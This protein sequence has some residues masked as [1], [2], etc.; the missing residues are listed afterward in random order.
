MTTSEILE[1]LP[2][3]SA[4]VVGDICLDRWCTYDPSEDEPSRETGIPRVGVISTTVTPGAGGT[5]ANNLAAMGVGRVSVLGAIGDDGFGHELRCAL[6]ARRIIAEHLIALPNVQ[7]FT[8]TK[9]INVAT[10]EEDLPRIDFVCNSPLNKQAEQQLLDKLRSNI[11]SFD[12]ILVSDQA[13]TSRGGVV[14]PALRQLLAELAVQYPD[15]IFMADSRTR[16][17]EFRNVIVKPNRQEAE[18]A[19]QK[20]FGAIDYQSLLR[21]VQSP[22]LFVTHGE[23]GVALITPEGEQRVAACKIAK[24][25]DIC[26]A[27]DSF[28]AGAAMA[29]AVTGSPIE[30]AQFGNLVASITIMKKGT[31]TASPEELSVRSAST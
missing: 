1:R 30:A 5:V 29:L 8:Y 12:V 25:V 23:E 27:G 2:K 15:K 17:E 19:C 22:F 9:L 3:L 18:T 10:G 16:I 14:T 4:L 7:T 26:G 6:G 28:T 11:D 21:H 31:G 13:E 20:L 24:P